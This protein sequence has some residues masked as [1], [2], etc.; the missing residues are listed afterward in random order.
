MN[1]QEATKLIAKI[2]VR[3][4]NAYQNFGPEDMME[5]RETMLEDFG[6][7]PFEVVD[8][9]LR[10]FAAN[11]VKGFP[12]STGMLMQYIDQ[13]MH[14]D[15]INGEAAWLMVKRSARCNPDSAMEQFRQLPDVIQK[16]IG[17]AG[18]LVDLG[19]AQDSEDAVRK[20]LFMRTYTETMKR[21][22]EDRKMSPDTQKKLEAFKEAWRRLGEEPMALTVDR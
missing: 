12:P 10:Q 6:H 14:P 8:A 15:D 11:D 5:L 16:T 3:Y 18:F 21:E 22:R 20:S 2:R 9:A 17:S 13:A 4:P 7:Y 1:V 19:Y